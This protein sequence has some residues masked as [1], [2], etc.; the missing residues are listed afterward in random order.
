MLIIGPLIA[1]VWAAVNPEGSHHFVEFVIWGR[2]PIGHLR[3]KYRTPTLH[4]L[5][6]DVPMARF[7]AIS[8]KEVPERSL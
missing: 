1:R 6:N 2:A 8:A 5:V 7:L 3:D 4:Y